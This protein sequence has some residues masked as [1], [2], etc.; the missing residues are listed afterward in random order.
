MCSRRKKKVHYNFHGSKDEHAKITKNAS[1][2]GMKPSNLMRKAAAG[3][4]IGTKFR[5]RLSSVE[6]NLEKLSPIKAKVKKQDAKIA[7]LFEI[8]EAMRTSQEPL[9][10]GLPLTH[11]Y[12]PTEKHA[13]I[14]EVPKS[15]SLPALVGVVFLLLG[16]WIGAATSGDPVAYVG[17]S[18][19]G[20]RIVLAPVDADA[21]TANPDKMFTWKSGDTRIDPAT[22]KQLRL[23]VQNWEVVETPKP[24][25]KPN[26][27]S[28]I[29]VGPKGD[30]I[31]TSNLW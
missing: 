17:R 28:R 29:F 15:W 27:P 10:Q 4:D 21:D 11:N 26:S 20:A 22:G 24:G 13:G 1:S 16:L 23:N 14:L 3:A 18:E 6:G 12:H 7:E 25:R 9:V 2:L 5:A 30:T 19:D 8:I 31:D